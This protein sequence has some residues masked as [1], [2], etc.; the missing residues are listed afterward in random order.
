[1]SD[2]ICASRTCFALAS[3]GCG[4]IRILRDRAGS[5]APM[6]IHWQM[7]G[8]RR[9][10]EATRRH[11]GTAYRRVLPPPESAS[12]ASPSWPVDGYGLVGRN[13]AM[14]V[15]SASLC[16]S[17][18]HSKERILRPPCDKV[19]WRPCL[20][21]RNCVVVGVALLGITGIALAQHQPV[22]EDG[23]EESLELAYSTVQRLTVPDAL[24]DAFT[25]RLA[26][27][28]RHHILDLSSYS[29][30]GDEF[31]VRVHDNRRQAYEVEPAP[32]CTYRGHVLD[33]P[34]SRV[35]ASLI[36]G[37]LTAAILM[38]DGTAWYVQPLSR[39]LPGSPASS[40]VVYRGSQVKPGNWLCGTG[41]AEHLGL[42]FV[43]KG[44]R[45]AGGG[46]E[47]LPVTTLIAFDADVEFYVLNGSSVA[48]TVGD[49]ES[50][51]KAVDN[52]FN[53]EVGI[54]YQIT[55]VIVRTTEPDP[56]NS[57]NYSVLLLALKDYWN[58][59]K[60]DVLRDVAH[61]MT[62]RDLDGNVIGVA[63]VGR[64]CVSP[65]PNTAYGLSQ[66]R[67][68][69]NFAERVALTA[70]ELGHNW[71]ATHC[72]MEGPNC[73][74]GWEPDC[75]IMCA[76]LGGCSGNLSE[77]G[78]SASGEIVA[79]ANSHDCFTELA[80]ACCLTDG[81]CVD[82]T[83]QLECETMMDGTFHGVSSACLSAA[84][85]DC[86]GNGVADPQDIAFGLS[87]DCNINTVPDECDIASGLS[88]DCDSNGV[89]DECDTS[90]IVELAAADGAAT[91]QFGAA[92]AIDG[93]VMVVGSHLDDDN[94]VDAGSAYV[95]RFSGSSWLEQAKLSASDASAGDDFGFSVAI[96]G[97]IVVVGAPLYDEG[98]RETGAAYIFQEP[99]GGWMN[100]T[101][102]ARLTTS[103]ISS[104]DQVGHSVAIQGNL[105]AVG[106]RKD[107]APYLDTGSA[108]V[109]VMPTGGWDSVPSSITEAAH[110]TGSDAEP[111]AGLGRSVSIS[112]DVV[113]VGADWKDGSM[114]YDSGAAYVFQEP[115][116][117]WAD[118]SETAKLVPADTAQ[119]DRFGY[120]VSMSGD[121]V[122]AGAPHD[123]DGG[124]QSGSAYV[125]LK[126]AGGWDAAPSPINEVDKLLPLDGAVN[127]QFG[128]SVAMSGDIVI[129]GAYLD[130]DNGDASG[131]AYRF[132]EPIDGWDSRPSPINETQKL[133]PS[134]GALADQF[135]Y[136]VAID[137]A[138]TAVGAY[139][140]DEGSLDSGSVYLFAA[141]GDCNGNL[142][143][144]ECDLATGAS[145][146]CNGNGAPDE[147][148]IAGGLSQDVNSDGV[149]D[150]CGPDCNGNGTPDDWDLTTGASQDC[151]SNSIPDECDIASGASQDINGN[152]VPDECKPAPANDDCID[153]LSISQG[154]TP[155]VTYF[156]TTDGFP[157][158]CDGGQP[159]PF[160]KDVWFTYIASCGGTMTISTCNDA[161]FDTIVGVYFDGAC[162][163]SAPL[164]CSNDAP[165][166]GLTSSVQLQAFAGFPYLVRVGGK[167]GASGTGNLTIECAPGCPEDLDGDGQVGVT[168][169]LDLLGQW[170]TNPG[171][172]PDFDD[173]G[174][175]GVTDLLQ[176][177]GGWG[178]C[179]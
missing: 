152:G 154:V 58:A 62:G 14:T 55:E 126:P 116:G 89:P 176:L 162:P 50:V 57:T 82:L 141:A 113:V 121:V 88:G 147:C 159:V 47:G 105:V 142:V 163:A 66:S 104:D 177:L 115:A 123:G 12:Q 110:L 44:G 112:G 132:Q 173:D 119:S 2:L 158:L 6:P 73:S 103:D 1:M 8:P 18:R 54:T 43:P 61:L 25:V 178:P 111:G 122:V 100:M 68:S 41:L 120:S 179:Q 144:D 133:L 38:D 60:G 127:D 117:G 108:Y 148:D 92:V 135:G 149:P 36:D 49:I 171:G 106:A 56:Y 157:L 70:H 125:F 175:V 80:G 21:V 22:I 42:G 136:A 32:P 3:H 74:G 78:S 145:G 65:P 35:A 4:R 13:A 94:G 39:V 166:C 160:Q 48:A 118:M 72:G 7:S 31:R 150:E 84:C 63:Y 76:C 139:G 51:L 69:P 161:D 67:F 165:G 26:L 172:S 20:T 153:A 46:P 130:D 37:Q 156:A 71:N 91:D 40:H 98:F 19:R 34:G 85:P 28:G 102:T 81:S 107:D 79:W 11:A 10:P 77:F 155:F 174:D 30:R 87:E 134:D 23:I 129:V 29:L 17:S 52:I 16:S 90:G 109:F 138:V 15:T 151:N 86:N 64:I 33:R 131:S 45:I 59:N 96:N 9:R 140:D 128:L 124:P 5:S 24:P 93:D 53:I 170:G 95:Y 146:D 167:Q 27:D 143:P 137:G 83:T 168:D 164:G 169:L 75:G 101:E 97:G 114:G 99:S